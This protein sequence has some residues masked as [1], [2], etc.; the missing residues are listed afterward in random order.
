[1]HEATKKVKDQR[2]AWEWPCV[3]YSIRLNK[4]RLLG[5][6]GEFLCLPPGFLFVGYL[7]LGRAFLLGGLVNKT[8]DQRVLIREGRFKTKEILA[9]GGVSTQPRLHPNWVIYRAF[10][11][12]L[13]ICFVVLGFC[14]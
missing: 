4:K 1:M 8:H 6:V 2:A 5:G 14:S 3:I 12:N 13:P 10:D 7:L 11:L 9:L